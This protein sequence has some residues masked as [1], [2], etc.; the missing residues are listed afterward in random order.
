MEITEEIKNLYRVAKV[1]SLFDELQFTN[2]VTQD[3]RGVLQSVKSG[4]I[5]VNPVLGDGKIVISDI[6]VIEE[7]IP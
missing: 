1:A 6:G 4:I 2:L 3:I 5:E 7:V